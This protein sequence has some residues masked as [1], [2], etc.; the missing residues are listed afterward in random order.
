MP[1][2]EARGTREGLVEAVPSHGTVPSFRVR[3][4]LISIK[5]AN[6]TVTHNVSTSC[7]RGDSVGLMYTQ[8]VKTYDLSD[9]TFQRKK[10]QQKLSLPELNRG[11]S[12]QKTIS[13]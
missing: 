11:V 13:I 7:R 9:L 10:Q 1:P 5:S 4:F 2:C 8:E 3:C 12:G 6:V